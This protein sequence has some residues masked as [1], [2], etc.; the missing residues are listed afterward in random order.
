MTTII[1]KKKPATVNFHLIRKW[2]KEVRADKQISL[3]TL[4][5]RT[6]YSTQHLADI[7]LGSHPLDITHLFVI[8]DGLECDLVLR[9]RPRKQHTLFDNAENLANANTNSTKKQKARSK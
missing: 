3:S 7:E 4:S 2:L 9:K 8:L 6:G 1:A 5:E